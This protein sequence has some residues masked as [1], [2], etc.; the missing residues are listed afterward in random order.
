[1]VNAFVAKRLKIVKKCVIVTVEEVEMIVEEAEMTVEEAEM[2][3]AVVIE[4][5]SLARKSLLEDLP[6]VPNLVS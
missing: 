3:V 4:N 5:A 1:M 6:F 2:T